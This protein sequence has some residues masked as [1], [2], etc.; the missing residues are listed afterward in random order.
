M[1]S[2]YHLLAAA[3]LPALFLLASCQG[4]GQV[5]NNA[6]IVP[7]SDVLEP[8]G[9][10][11]FLAV[12]ATGDWT[13]TLEYPAGTEDWATADP[14]SGTGSRADVRLRYDANTSELERSVIIVLKP[15]NGPSASASVT[16]KGVSSGDKPSAVGGYGEDTARPLW[17]ELPATKTGDGRKFYA[18]DMTGYGYR[19]FKTSGVRNWSF[20]WDETEHMALWVAYPLNNSLKGTGSRTNEWGFDPLIAVDKQ[21]S[22]IGGSYGGGWTRGHQLPS[23]DRLSHDA[24]VSTFYGTNMT[25]QEYNFNSFIWGNLEGRVRD[26]AAKADTLYVVTGALFDNSQARSGT[27]SGFAV[28][29]PTHYF[30]A[31]LYSGPS[32]YAT[33]GYMMAGFFLPHD[34]SIAKGNCLDYMMS[35]DALEQQTGIDFFPNL[36][37]VLG[38]A[39]ADALEAEAPS[40][41]WK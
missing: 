31:L 22:L 25:P 15:A 28:K 19:G 11:I 39:A 34:T 30:K 33:G 36:A 20:Y 27:S 7:R 8:D 23:A 17:L 35:I 3:M 2:V 5:D 18:H 26:Y 14:A 12:T 38:K 32:S 6:S 9:G 40:K 41:F 13:I 37:G 4:G 1:K 21:P 16:Q 29:I 10:S 24:N